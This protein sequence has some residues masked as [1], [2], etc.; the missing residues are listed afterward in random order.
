MTYHSI[1][2]AN[3]CPPA[4]RRRRARTAGFTVLE[5]AVAGALL[6]LFLSSLFAMN[7]TVLRMLRS[8]NETSDAS[9]ELQTRIEQVRLANWPQ[10]TDPSWVQT[11]LLAQPTDAAGDLRG[12]SERIEGW[13][14]GASSAAFTV[15]RNADGSTT[16]TGSSLT[17]E[18]YILVHVNVTWPSWGGRTRSRE[19][20]TIV[21][22]GGISK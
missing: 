12:L 4:G 10:I 13:R 19:L 15:S 6:T 9:Q 5:V 21:A 18:E 17:T 20:V 16:S 7:S 11:R 2:Q 3:S 14:P 1:F 8:A 22:K